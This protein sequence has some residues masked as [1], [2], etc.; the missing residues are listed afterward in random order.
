V[1][2]LGAA[3]GDTVLVRPDGVVAWRGRDP[4]DVGAALR[5]VLAR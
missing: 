3:P 4:G 2:P 1:A 5:T